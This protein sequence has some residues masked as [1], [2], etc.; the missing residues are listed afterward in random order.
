MIVIR[1]L[2]LESLFGWVGH[3]DPLIYQSMVLVLSLPA[4]GLGIF[5]VWGFGL[6]I[7]GSEIQG[8]EIQGLGIQLGD[9]GFG[10]S[11]LGEG[12]VNI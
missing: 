10:D 1:S 12:V 3:Q 9:S 8:L 6:G 11:G 4:Q 7:Q 2:V 5:R